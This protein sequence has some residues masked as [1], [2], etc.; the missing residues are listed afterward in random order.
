[1]SGKFRYRSCEPELLDT[2]SIPKDLLYK[3]LYELDVLNRV[4]GGH[5]ASISGIKQLIMDKNRTYHIVDLGCGSGDALKYIADWA[6][7]RNYKVMLT[8][9]DVNSDTIKYLNENCKD[10][11]EITGVVSD[12]R[13]F[14]KFA[15]S[16]DIIH[17]SL[18]CHHLN[19]FEIVEMLRYFKFCTKAGFVINDLRRN[20]FSYYGAWILTRLLN[21][22]SLAKNDGPLSVLRGFTLREIHLI[23]QR[24]QLSNYCVKKKWA[25]RYLI[26]GR[27]EHNMTSN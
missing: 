16:I 9:V 1:M 22:S 10:Y 23:F 15:K 20:R 26:T 8:G 21:A 7:G 2:P 3:N 5:L 14:L 18:F 17:C 11:P 19:D 24:A 27:S 6:R 12:Y 13:T 25:F 4:L